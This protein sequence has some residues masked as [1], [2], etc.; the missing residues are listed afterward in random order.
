M[1]HFNTK[2]LFGGMIAIALFA[3]VS[4]AF[5]DEVAVSGIRAEGSDTKAS[6]ITK[7]DVR[8]TRDTTSGSSKQEV[9]APRLAAKAEN[10]YAGVFGT[11]VGGVNYAFPGALAVNTTTLS[12]YYPLVVDNGDGNK[13]EF[14]KG[15]ANIRLTSKAS[16]VTG[17]SIQFYKAG[18][19]PVCCGSIRT[20]NADGLNEIR[21][22]SNYG[23]VVLMA[24]SNPLSTLGVKPSGN[25]YIGEPADTYRLQVS[26]TI[27]STS[28]GFRF[29]DGTTQ[30]SAAVSMG[31]GVPAISGCDSGA[32]LGRISVDTANNRIYVCV[33]G[34][35]GWDYATLND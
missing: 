1:K 21:L 25:V 10:V 24:N 4:F 32:E 30:T 18:G 6:V 23:S 17:P 3:S 2:V 20:E 11:S 9:S 8:A 28:G 14:M 13:T 7:G 22:Q 26:G 33:G 29:P 16:G 35:R 5:A 19:N 15:A 12:T 34:N 27:Y 31:S